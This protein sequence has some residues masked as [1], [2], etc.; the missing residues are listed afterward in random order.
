VIRLK[1]LVHG[2]RIDRIRRTEAERMVRIEE[3][4][5]PLAGNLSPLIGPTL[6]KENPSPSGGGRTS[7]S[8]E[9][10]DRLRGPERGA[11][12]GD[13]EKLPCPPR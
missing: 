6:G 8:Q 11:G 2:R 1:P 12:R 10:E 13:Q 5:D 7:L 4:R 3:E 9:R